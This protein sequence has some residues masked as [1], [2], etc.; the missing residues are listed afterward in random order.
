M[1]VGPAV[2]HYDGVLAGAFEVDLGV[3]D[4]DCFFHGGGPRGTFRQKNYYLKI[5]YP[6]G[7]ASAKPE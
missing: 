7:Q 2:E 3:V 1:G 6:T 4:R 5:A